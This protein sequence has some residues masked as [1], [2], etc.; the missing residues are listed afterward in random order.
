[1]TK[2]PRRLMRVPVQISQY[3]GGKPSTREASPFLFMVLFLWRGKNITYVLTIKESPKRL[4]LTSFNPRG[5]ERRQS[6]G[7]YL[8]SERPFPRAHDRFTGPICTNPIDV[9]FP[10]ADHEV[11]MR[12][13]EI[14][15]ICLELVFCH[16]APAIHRE[17][18]RSPDGNMRGGV[19]IKQGVIEQV[20]SPT[21]RR[22]VGDE[23]HFANA[24]CTFI[25]LDQ[26]SQRLFAFPGCEVCDSAVLKCHCK[27]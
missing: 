3:V 14:A 21:D 22:A 15:A 25:G 23:G 9:H 7:S 11:I 4:F 5:V 27:V 8:Y 2:P 16:S 6:G 10:R 19:F 13:A 20:T 26:F 1:M 24:S 17:A 12:E 18:V